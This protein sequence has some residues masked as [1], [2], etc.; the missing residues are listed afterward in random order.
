VSP[1]VKAVATVSPHEEVRAPHRTRG[2]AVIEEVGV[3]V[4]KEPF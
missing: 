3:E 2:D 4:I 1:L